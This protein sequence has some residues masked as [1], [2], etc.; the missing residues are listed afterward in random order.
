[1]YEVGQEMEDVLGEYKN[2]VVNAVEGLQV[3]SWEPQEE[4][5]HGDQDHGPPMQGS[6]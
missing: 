6:L 5:D 2:E 1:M 3:W 4:E